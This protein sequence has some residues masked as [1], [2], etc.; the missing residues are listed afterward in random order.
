LHG[1]YAF[2]F[3]KGSPDNIA[4]FNFRSKKLRPLALPPEAT[5]LTM[6]AAS[7]KAMVAV[8]EN[9][10]TGY[11]DPQNLYRYDNRTG[12]RQKLDT[13][14]R[15][16]DW[17]QDEIRP[18]SIADDGTVIAE[19]LTFVP[20]PSWCLV[21]ASRSFLRQYP[22]GNSP[23]QDVWLPAKYQSWLRDQRLA[24]NG[25]TLA[26]A[27]V[28]TLIDPGE[29]AVLD[30]AKHEVLAGREA[31]DIST[32]SLANPHSLY[33]TQTDIPIGSIGSIAPAITKYWRIGGRPTALFRGTMLPYSATN[34]G[35]RAL[36]ATGRRLWIVDRKR[37]TVFKRRV[38]KQHTVG[39]IVCSADHL[40]YLDF[41]EEP[42]DSPGT[43]EF[44]SVKHTV[45]ISKLP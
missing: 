31:P 12:E 43:G 9:N 3:T 32:L 29:I 30:I 39:A 36:L 38:P 19:F 37:R 11:S 15:G 28:G 42:D 24:A 18:L 10:S 27:N 45:D 22:P 25:N 20:G 21:D 1:N 35:N 40:Q 5:S 4:S 7:D 17:C 34:C 23:A 41:D 44:F 33:Y 13:I 14:T 6:A 8:T 2:G 26:I 16:A